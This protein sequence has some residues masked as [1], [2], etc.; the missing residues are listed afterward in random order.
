VNNVRIA[1]IQVHPSNGLSETLNQMR[2]LEQLS[3]QN[4]SF[5]KFCF[6]NFYSNCSACIPGKIWNYIKK[7]FQYI[8]DDY[9]ET[10]TAPYVLLET[11]KGDCDDF[12]LFA[13][14][15]LD[16]LEIYSEQKLGWKTSYLLLGRTREGFTHIVCFAHRGKYLFGFNDPVIIDGANDLFNTVSNEYKFRKLIQ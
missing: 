9:D 2:Y 13:K 4:P 1:N 11:K 12:A 5:I 6:D 3:I 14:T 7:N 15:C 10:I 16:I 8:E